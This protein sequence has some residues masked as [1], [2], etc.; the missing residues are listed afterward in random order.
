MLISTYSTKSTSTHIVEETEHQPDG[1][2][3]CD[4]NWQSTKRKV[5]NAK[6]NAAG[7]GNAPAFPGVVLESS[8]AGSG[9]AYPWQGNRSVGSGSPGCRGAGDK[10]PNPRVGTGSKQGRRK[11]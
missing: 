3:G 9:C 4:V 11:L 7:L 6:A 2:R 1:P 10:C 8:R 5:D